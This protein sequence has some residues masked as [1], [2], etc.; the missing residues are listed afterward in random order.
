V[1]VGVE[2]AAD[3][4]FG[5]GVGLAFDELA[6]FGAGELGFVGGAGDYSYT[7]GGVVVVV[8]G[9]A[10]AGGPAEGEGGVV[11]AEVD[12]VS[13]VVVG[14]E[15]DVRGDFFGGEGEVAHEGGELVDGDGGLVL[16]ELGEELGEVHGG[17]PGGGVGAGFELYQAYMGWSSYRFEN[18]PPA[19]SQREGAFCFSGPA[20]TTPFGR[21]PW[22]PRLLYGYAFSCFCCGI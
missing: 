16:V 13:L 7:T 15:V 2:G 6:G 21:C 9:A 17:F 19:P 14:I 5:V 12:E 20:R 11:L 10:L 4:G 8:D 1:D 18:P 3:G 22:H